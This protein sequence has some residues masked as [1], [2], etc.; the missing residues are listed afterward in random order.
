MA[1][2]TVKTTPNNPIYE[3]AREIWLAGL[4][5]FAMARDEGNKL[6]ETLVENGRDLEAKG[7]SAATETVTDIRDHVDSKFS[8]V[9]DL[10]EKNI[11]KI[12]QVFDDRVASVL[13]R[14]G[15]PSANEIALLTKRVE[16]LGREV[17]K[18]NATKRTAVKPA[19]TKAVAAKPATPKKR[20]RTK[21]A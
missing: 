18:L 21:A 10:A 20:T 17:K 15:V 12:E 14:L 8:G 7:R 6:F 19:V 1:K 2:K 3:S 9:R 5:A 16:E 11:D 13:T 4:G